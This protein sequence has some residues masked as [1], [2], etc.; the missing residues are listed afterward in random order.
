M[1][2]RPTFLPDPA[3]LY[4]LVVFLA[5]VRFGGEKVLQDGDTHWHIRVGQII[6]ETGQLVTSDTFSHT[7]F[8]KPWL[9][10][11][12]LAEVF[13][14]VIYNLGGLPAVAISHLLLAA[15]TFNLLYLCAR[16]LSGEWAT[17]AAISL[18]VPMAMTHLLARPHLFTWLLGAITLYCLIRNDKSLWLLPLVTAIWGNLHGGVLLGLVLQGGFVAG[19]LMDRWP[20]IRV[21]NWASWLAMHKRL[22]IVLGL[23]T[24]ATGCNPF[25]FYPFL[26]NIDVSTEIFSRSIGEWK[27]VDFQAKWYIRA[28]FI[29]MFAMAASSSRDND[30]HWKLL[31]PTLLFLAMTHVRHVSIAALFSAPWLAQTLGHTCKSLSFLPTRRNLP[32]KKQLALSS[33]SGPCLTLVTSLALFYVTVTSPPFWKSFAD[34][35][36]PMPEDYSQGAIDYIATQ[37]PAGNILLNEYSWGDYLIYAL[38]PPPPVFIDGRADMYGVEIFKDY[39][40]VAQLREGTDVIMEKYAIDWVLFPKDHLLVRYLLKHP[41]WQTVF[42]D[43]NTIILALA[44]P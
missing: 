13:M 26:F 25:G 12:W 33:W 43:D 15:L 22:V 14:V 44:R 27:A 6:L 17:L 34:K 28:W 32:D 19:K 8:G 37:G 36:F 7:A 2:S 21:E 4:G 5:L 3:G 40:T 30:W 18:T 29:G 10:H 20:G 11:E 35:R 39:L 16:R 38:D 9:A 1:K 31:I 41:E 24:L 42:S 23:S